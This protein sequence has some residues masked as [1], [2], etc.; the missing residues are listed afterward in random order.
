MKVLIVEDNSEQ[1]K[2]L[3]NIFLNIDN[4][5]IVYLSDCYKDANQYIEQEKFDIIT[6][7]INLPDGN[8]LDL[9]DQ[10][11]E[12][13]KDK[14]KKP[15]IIVITI[16]GKHILKAYDEL[17]VRKYM[18]KPYEKEK[19]EKILKELSQYEIRKQEKYCTFQ[20]K[21]V[22]I[23]IPETDILYMEII[24]RE[25]I[26]FDKK[27]NNYNLGRK[28]I[29]TILEANKH[30][31]LLRC[32]KSIIVNADNIIRIEKKGTIYIIYLQ[33]DKAI[34]ASSKYIKDIKDKIQIT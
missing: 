24:N 12:F 28:S 9:V 14:D 3:K 1:L 19:V 23:R 15:W 32:Y 17:G 4:S 6:I 31:S 34:P 10:I 13:Y 11:N 27:S 20:G 8:G 7:D 16:E 26:L 33:S 25:M 21:R 22:C 29:K 2:I 30:T 5:N 18:T